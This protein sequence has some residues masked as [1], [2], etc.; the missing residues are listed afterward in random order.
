MTDEEEAKVETLFEMD[1]ESTREDCCFTDKRNRVW[2][3][4]I[5]GYRMYLFGNKGITLE[6]FNNNKLTIGQLMDLIYI[7]CESL[8]TKRRETKETFLNL[9]EGDVFD[10]AMEAVGDAL[11]NFFRSP[12]AEKAKAKALAEEESAAAEEAAVESA[13]SQDPETPKNEEN[14]TG[15]TTS[16]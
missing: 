15:E 4:K 6:T 9:L 8:A 13:G 10:D 14:G 5:S 1:E 7:S 3:C 2:L 16:T 11:V 12:R